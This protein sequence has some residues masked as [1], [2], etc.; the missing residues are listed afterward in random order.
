MLLHLLLCEAEFLALANMQVDLVSDVSDYGG[1][2]ENVR[3]SATQERESYLN[4][5]QGRT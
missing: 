4:L 2:L 1:S 3:L 5:T